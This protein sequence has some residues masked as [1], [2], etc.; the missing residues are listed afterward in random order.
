VTTKPDPWSR[1][2][3][4]VQVVEEYLESCEHTVLSPF[5]PCAVAGVPERK[6]EYAFREQLGATSMRYLRLRRLNGVRRGAFRHHAEAE[7][8]EAGAPA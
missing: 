1:R 2:C 3:A 4:V 5:D 6:L 8:I 7:A